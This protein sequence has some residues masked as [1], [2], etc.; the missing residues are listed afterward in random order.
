MSYRIIT[1]SSCDL[2]Q[3]EYEKW[4]VTMVPL[5]VLY[6]GQTYTDFSDAGTKKLYDG[7][8]SGECPTTSAANPEH[9]KNAMLPWLDQGQ[10]V[11]V[12][13]FS[14][15][16]STTYQSA[17]IAAEDLREAYPQRKIFVVDSL[18]ASMGQGLLLW[19]ACKH[20]D[21]GMDIEA[22]ASWLEE[23][24]CHLCHWFTVDDLMHLK[25]GGRVS[26]STALVGTMLNIKPVLH[27]DDEGHLINMA[28]ARGRKASIEMLAKKLEELGEG[29]DNET[30]FISHGD[31]V[32]DA[33]LLAELVKQRCGVKNAVISYVGPVIGSHTG[34][35]VLAFFFLGKHR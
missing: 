22:L 20:R 21:E 35:G 2:P 30:V 11:L 27:M 3:G 12:L 5:T 17:V 4:N 15:G 33:Q 8:R 16:L 18:S 13:A 34:P 32:S 10:D 14:S 7:L 9:W 24:R 25:R 26:A 1:D 19:Y 6:Q 23:N 29:Y 31:C 28:K